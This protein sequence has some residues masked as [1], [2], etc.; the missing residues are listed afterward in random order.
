MADEVED[1]TSWAGQ[2][3]AVLPGHDIRISVS[4]RP[5]GPWRS[6]TELA[7]PALWPGIA[8]AYAHGLGSG[9]EPMG[10]SCALQ[11]LTARVTGPVIVGWTLSGAIPADR[12]EGTWVHVRDGRSTAIA[13]ADSLSLAAV[14][15]PHDLAVTVVDRVRPLV[16][17]VR[18]SSPV[19]DRVLWGNVGAACA[20]AWRLAHLAGRDPRIA[21]AAERFFAAPVWPHPPAIRCDMWPDLAGTGPVL[22]HHRETCCLIHLAPDHTKCP[23]CSKLTERERRDRWTERI[24]STLE[25]RA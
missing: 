12:P 11:G 10:A 23:P 25:V 2:A 9:I 18:A 8:R 7:D 14:D 15:D 20:G 13:L 4:G 3:R 17:A 5:A 1:L 6:L 16:S 19:V 24:A 22:V 21:Q